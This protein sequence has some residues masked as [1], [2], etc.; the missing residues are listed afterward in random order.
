MLRFHVLALCLIT[1]MVAGI[2][3]PAS[4]Q[5]SQTY[6]LS[7]YRPVELGNDNGYLFS[8]ESLV[9]SPGDDGMGTVYPDWWYDYYLENNS[10]NHQIVSWTWSAGSAS[11]AVMPNTHP[12][13]TVPG[14]S[15]DMPLPSATGPDISDASFREESFDDANPLVEVGSTI[16]WEDQTVS[17]CNIYVPGN[18]VPEPGSMLALATGMIG[19]LGAFGRRRK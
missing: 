1:I 12:G 14:G 3:I 4:A 16:T 8:Y 5:V 9:Q 17:H 6:S 15:Y 13:T 10:L 2:G 7:S 11:G 19:L 18:L